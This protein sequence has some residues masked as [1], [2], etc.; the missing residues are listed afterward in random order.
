MCRLYGFRATHPTRVQCELIQAQN[1]LMRQS[2]K[3]ERGLGNPDGWGLGTVRNGTLSCEREV[4]PAYESEEYRRDAARV[5][6]RTV[7]AH[8][9]RATVGEARKE[10]THPFRREGSMLAHNGHI[11]AFDELR[12]RLLEKM[13][14]ELERGIRGTTDSEH[15]FHLLISRLRERLAVAPDE[16]VTEAEPGGEVMREVLGETVE[17]L[18]DWCESDL[19]DLDEV[20]RGPDGKR[21]DRVALNLLWTVGDCLAGSRLG[22]SLWYVERDGARRCEDCGE[23]HPDP[24][25]DGYR[26]VAIASER[27][28]GEDWTEVP[29]ASVFHVDDEMR[30][31]AEFL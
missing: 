24:E 14:P 19:P 20:P 22:R 12:P 4:G 2:E 23:M 26:S 8:V 9:R 3:D 6:A 29:E 21:L 11:P 15:V 18:V 30:L 31:Q 27:I 25:P 1:S 5:D 17:E 28:T 16:E 7:L 10:N 13:A